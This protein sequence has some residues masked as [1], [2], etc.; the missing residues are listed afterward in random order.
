MTSLSNIN[1][2][3]IPKNR[4]KKKKLIVSGVAPD[5]AQKFEGVKRWCEVRVSQ[6]SLRLELIPLVLEFR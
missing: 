6:I 1:I 3:I 2:P 4:R 5:D